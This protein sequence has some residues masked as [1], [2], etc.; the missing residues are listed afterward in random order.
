MTVT[1]DAT[2]LPKFSRGIAKRKRPSGSSPQIYRERAVLHPCP[3]PVLVRLLPPSGLTRNRL[4]TP[5]WTPPSPPS[6]TLVASPR[7][8][9]GKMESCHRSRFS[10]QTWYRLHS[11]TPPLVGCLWIPLQSRTAQKYCVPTST[12]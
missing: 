1:H 2:Q 3:T 8:R 7:G 9:R 5:G 11:P 4:S 12:L 10:L 6:S